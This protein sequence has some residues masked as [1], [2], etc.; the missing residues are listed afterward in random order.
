MRSLRITGSL[1]TAGNGVDRAPAANSRVL[2]V[3]ASLLLFQWQVNFSE[4]S[5]PGCNRSV[6]L[7][8]FWQGWC[9]ALILP[10][11]CPS[12]AVLGFALGVDTVLAPLSAWDVPQGQG[13]AG[14]LVSA[15]VC[16]FLACLHGPFSHLFSHPLLVPGAIQPLPHALGAA[17]APFVMWGTP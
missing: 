13:S 15:S 6:G 14:A 9:S 7:W 17:P 10:A 5:A 3:G 1:A 16:P 2:M 4:V 12:E 11:L 8:L